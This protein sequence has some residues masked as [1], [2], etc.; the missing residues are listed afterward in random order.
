MTYRELGKW[1]AAR[2]EFGQ[3]RDLAQRLNL[4]GDL[5]N[6][7][8]GLASVEWDLG[9]YELAIVLNQK[10]AAIYRDEQN[11][12]GEADILGD[13]GL[14]YQDLGDR[15]QAQTYHEKSLELNRS[16]GHRRGEASQ[17]SNL[18][19]IDEERGDL[20]SAEDKLE[21]ALAID[22][23]LGDRLGEAADCGNLGNIYFRRN[24]WDQA[25]EAYTRS[26]DLYR[27]AGQRQGEMRQLFG[28]GNVLLEQ[29]HSAE[30]RTYFDQALFIAAELGDPEAKRI[31]HLL[32]GDAYQQEGASDKTRAHYEES[33]KFADFLRGQLIR[34]EHK[35]TFPSGSKFRSY[36]RLVLLLYSTDVKESFQNVERLKSR[37]LIDQLA[38]TLIRPSGLIHEELLRE[39]TVLL[40]QFHE[41]NGALRHSQLI[42][43]EWW[44]EWNTV[45]AALEMLWDKIAESAPEYVALRKARPS[46]YRDLQSILA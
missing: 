16:L 27:E 5:A 33:A 36:E 19:L 22:R 29:N 14:I 37:L 10:A 17:L 6:A 38:Y 9:N 43:P 40:S 20:G 18:A 13:L 26:L 8:E 4:A 7:L 1:Q 2:D 41:L 44:I 25:R 34:A 24:G 45:R 21:K 35:T 11:A 46:S 39:E 32:L 23:E 12:A 3:A 15:I 31:I 28:L 42:A 30:A